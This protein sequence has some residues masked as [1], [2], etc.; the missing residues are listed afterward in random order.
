MRLEEAIVHY[1]TA[2]HSNDLKIED[3]SWKWGDVNASGNPLKT[4]WSSGK[5]WKEVL[6]DLKEEDA[7]RKSR[8]VNIKIRR[9]ISG[10][11]HEVEKPEP[12]DNITVAKEEIRSLA[13]CTKKVDLNNEH[14]NACQ[15]R[16][17]RR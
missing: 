1:E 11:L 17:S 10:K 12:R 15:C 2:R 8:Q 6:K 7:R 13:N 5:S 16:D 4:S 14:R 9:S 3:V